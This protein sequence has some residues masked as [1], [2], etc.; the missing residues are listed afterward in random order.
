VFWSCTTAC[1]YC[2]VSIHDVLGVI[3]GV[4]VNEGVI[5]GV[6]LGVGVKDGVMLGVTDGVAVMLGVTDGDNGGD[7]IGSYWSHAF[8]SSKIVTGIFNS[9]P[10]KWSLNRSRNVVDVFGRSVSK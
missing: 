10:P 4:G 2:V 7:G 9:T 8:I 3:D 1:I 6:I 5:D